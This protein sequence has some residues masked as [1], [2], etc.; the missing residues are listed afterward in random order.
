MGNAIKA[1]YRDMEY[2]RTLIKKREALGRPTGGGGEGITDSD[3][4]EADAEEWTLVENDSDPEAASPRAM[5]Q[6]EPARGGSSRKKN[7]GLM[8]SSLGRR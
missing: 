8:H 5:M 1:I 2:A 6:P 4:E 7:P 3:E